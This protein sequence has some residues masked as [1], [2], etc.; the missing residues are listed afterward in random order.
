MFL[1][2]DGRDKFQFSRVDDLEAWRNEGKAT[3]G[4]ILANRATASE[5]NFAV[6]KSAALLERLTNTRP[7]L[8]QVASRIYQ[9]PITSADTVYLFE[10][11]RTGKR[12]G[13]VEVFSRELQ[14]WVALER[15]ILKPVVRSGDIG[16]YAATPSVSALFPYEVRDSSARLLTPDEMK[17]SWT[18]GWD[19]LNRNKKLLQDREGGK[20]R[21][22]E[23]YRYGRT[24]NLGMWEQPKLMVPYMTTRL[25][26]YLDRGDGFYFINVTTG[27]YGLTVDDR[28]VQLPYLC[29]LLNSRLLDFCFRHVSTTFHGGYFAA[30]K[31]FI[32]QLPIRTINLPGP[33]DK[34]RHDKMPALVE[35][36]LELNKKKYSDKLAP[37]ELDHTESEIAATDLEIDSLVYELYGIT[38]EERRIVE[39]A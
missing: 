34:A 5:W 22:S 31:Q 37:S 24:Q 10:Q 26:A 1:E 29:A 18:L 4:A 20:F 7:K 11:S 39:G 25:A 15:D 35:R 8:G 6:G 14:D 13:T 17:R 36:M 19:Y 33:A 28:S 23:W 9:G 30:N 27:G 21:D 3:E 32:E 12:R 16:R 2:K 38:D